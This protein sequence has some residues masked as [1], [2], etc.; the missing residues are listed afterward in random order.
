MKALAPLLVCML[1]PFS[2]AK[3]NSSQT[4]A[5]G[6]CI[7]CEKSGNEAV[8]NLENWFA[9]TTSQIDAAKCLRKR[10]F[11]ESE[12]LQ[13]FESNIP[14]PEE[15][16]S[17]TVNGIN[18]KNESPYML[19][20]FRDLHET[21]VF[22]ERNKTLSLESKC[23][24][25]LCAVNEIYGK[26]NGTQ[27]LFMLGK[28]GFNGSRIRTGLADN[29]SPWRSHE[30]DEI[31]VSLDALPPSLHPLDYNRQLLKFKRGYIKRNKP[32]TIANSR[33][34]V[35]DLW[36]ES[37][38][39]ER[40][41][42][43]LHEF[44]HVQAGDKDEKSL[45]LRASGWEK[46]AKP[47]SDEDYIQRGNAP[48]SYGGTSPVEDYAESLV[49]YRL[50][51]NNFKKNFPE[52][53]E[54]MKSMVFGGLEFTSQAAC[55][56][57]WK[58]DKAQQDSRLAARQ[59]LLEKR[60]KDREAAE[61]IL[62]GFSSPIRRSFSA[63]QLQN[64]TIQCATELV[65]EAVH[66]TVEGSLCI[67][68]EIR[69]ITLSEAIKNSGENID[70]GSLSPEQ[71]SRLRVDN[72]TLLS[73]RTHVATEL[74]EALEKTYDDHSVRFSSNVGECRDISEYSRVNL[75]GVTAHA[76]LD[77]DRKLKDGASLRALLTK[78]CEAK[79]KSFGGSIIPQD[80][81]IFAGNPFKKVFG[82]P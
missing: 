47:G 36:N 80:I 30:L 6:A 9:A 63:N 71:L 43:M 20:L 15:K 35:F 25:V 29:Y 72:N 27:L 52:R 75:H 11:S 53:Y 81:N 65:R 13:F 59:S 44:A 21:D 74:A 51:S 23:D 64:M 37:P 28:F 18:F 10:P 49:G 17:E 68:N 45:W 38:R 55:E 31:L 62:A 60:K 66:N 32:N 5:H 46:Q 58:Q 41:S 24:K 4:E 19:K 56:A 78:A 42:T 22:W 2:I 82:L 79:L 61:K 57:A 34:E 33:I 50:N 26:P 3:A 77:E 7:D 70:M 16:K 40:L 48:S 8:K 69:R 76:L 67:N 1:L 54:Y 14:D 39:Q 73:V 12:M